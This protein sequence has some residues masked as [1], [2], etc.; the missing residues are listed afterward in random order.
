VAVGAGSDALYWT[1]PGVAASLV[2]TVVNARV[3]LIEILR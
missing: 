3:L 1:I 2:A